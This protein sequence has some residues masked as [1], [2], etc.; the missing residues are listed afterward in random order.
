VRT[1]KTE[2]SGFNSKSI[3]KKFEK[4]GDQD[5]AESKSEGDQFEYASEKPSVSDGGSTT[6][7]DI[8]IDDPKLYSFKQLYHLVSVIVEN[9]KHGDTMNNLQT[10][11]D[12]INN[13]IQ[14]C[15]S[16]DRKINVKMN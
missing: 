7:T 14:N 4:S 13:K 8:K 11:I 1:L 15:K 3:Q 16:E 6:E 2:E 5:Q 12:E 9:S 10:Q